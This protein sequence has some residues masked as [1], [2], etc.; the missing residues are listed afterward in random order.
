MKSQRKTSVIKI[1]IILPMSVNHVQRANDLQSI[2]TQVLFSH[3]YRYFENGQYSKNWGKQC[4]IINS[5]NKLKCLKRDFFFV[6]ILV[7]L[8]KMKVVLDIDRNRLCNKYRPYTD[9]IDSWY[10]SFLGHNL[11]QTTMCCTFYYVINNIGNVAGSK[12]RC[13]DIFLLPN[14]EYVI[15]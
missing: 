8:I 11:P 15:M 5:C 2:Y 4:S 14:S 7:K 12:D 9:L 10:Q 1:A 13:S 3:F 6:L